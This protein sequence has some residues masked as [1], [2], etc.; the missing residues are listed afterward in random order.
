M[1]YR[2]VVGNILQLEDLLNNARLLLLPRVGLPIGGRTLVFSTPA[3]T[4][5]FPGAAGAMV[6]PVAIAT[7]LKGVSGLEVELRQEGTNNSVSLR[8]EG[9]FTIAST[10]TANSDFSLSTTQATVVAAPVPVARVVAISQGA[11]GGQ[12]VALLSSTP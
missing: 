5:T 12:L 7:A 2:I 3:S 9:G 1:T 8:R 10:G 4:V 6:A 11:E